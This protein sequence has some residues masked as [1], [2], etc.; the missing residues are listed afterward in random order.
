MHKHP[1]QMTSHG[2]Q[3]G[4]PHVPDLLNDVRPVDT[5]RPLASPKPAHQCSLTIGPGDDVLVVEAVR[6][7]DEIGEG[8][9]MIPVYGRG[10]EPLPI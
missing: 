5:V 9:A 10:H 1:P 4:Q 6:H 7:A 3:L 8:P 2:A